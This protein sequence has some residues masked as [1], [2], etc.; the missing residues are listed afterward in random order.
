MPQDNLIKMECTVCKQT[1]YYSRKNKK[2]IKERL[3]L[4]KLCK[5]C[6][7]HTLHKETK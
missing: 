6:R 2:V 4:K 7:K 3:E 5:H 1:N